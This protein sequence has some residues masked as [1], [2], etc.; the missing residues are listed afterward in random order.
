[1]RRTQSFRFLLQT[2]LQQQVEDA[3]KQLKKAQEELAKSQKKLEVIA[4]FYCCFCAVALIL[5]CAC[6]RTANQGGRFEERR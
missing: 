5:F 1:M 2:R 6:G 3:N 4:L